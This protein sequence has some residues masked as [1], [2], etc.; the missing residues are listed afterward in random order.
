[1]MRRGRILPDG[2]DSPILGFALAQISEA[3][4]VP[5]DADLTASLRAGKGRSKS[6]RGKSS[7]GRA[8]TPRNAS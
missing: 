7:K 3:R 5:D 6:N 2:Y 1:M 4:L 8:A